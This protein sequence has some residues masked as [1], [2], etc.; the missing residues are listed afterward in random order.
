VKGFEQRR[1]Q[2]KRIWLVAISAALVVI[3]G[4][5]GLVLAQNSGDEPAT[6]TGNSNGGSVSV[7]LSNQQVGIWVNGEGKVSVTPDLAVLQ[8]GI[9]AQSTTVSDAQSQASAAMDAV[10]KVLKDNGV[11]DKDIKTQYFSINRVTRW[12]DKTQTEEVIGYRV[13]NLVTVKIRAIAKAGDIIDTVA[14][15]GGDLT[16]INSISFT[17]E[18]PAA[19]QKEAREKAMADA[20]AKAEQLAKAS[21]VTLGKPTYVNDTSYFATYAVPMAGGFAGRDAAAVSTPISPGETDITV[22]IQV[23]YAI[24]E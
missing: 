5:G 14:E 17:V 3:L 12:V 18:N 9:E 16:R 7:N 15:A 24:I 23:T 10:M 11:A 20:K 19:A 21:G 8:L 2:M 13:T 4:I 6:S 1:E 22:N